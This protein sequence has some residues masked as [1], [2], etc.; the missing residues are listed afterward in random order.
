MS[1]NP[2][3][4]NLTHKQIWNKTFNLQQLKFLPDKDC[5]WLT[6]TCGPLDEFIPSFWSWRS[7]GILGKC[8]PLLFKCRQNNRQIIIQ[9]TIYSSYF[10]LG[11]LIDLIPIYDLR[12]PLDYGYGY[13]NPSFWVFD[14]IKDSFMSPFLYKLWSSQSRDTTYKL[15]FYYFYGIYIRTRIAYPLVIFNSFRIM[16]YPLDNL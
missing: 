8:F 10:G 4:I 7:H 15:L 13:G 14:P 16:V 6:L 12:F 11:I 5:L 2:C 1:H 9:N 3:Q